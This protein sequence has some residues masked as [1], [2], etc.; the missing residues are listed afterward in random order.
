MSVIMFMR[1][2]SNNE[3]QFAKIRKDILLN[4]T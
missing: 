2:Q 4:T 3:G 1:L